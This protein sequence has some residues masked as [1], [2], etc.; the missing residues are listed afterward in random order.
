MQKLSLMK[1][2]RGEPARRYRAIWVLGFLGIV[3]GAIGDFSALSLASQSVVAPLGSWTLAANMVVAPLIVGEKPAQRE[4]LATLVIIAGCALSVL[5]ANHKTT[6]Y[7][8]QY[9]LHLYVT[10]KGSLYFGV[11]AGVIVVSLL[12]IRY[13]ERLEVLRG[14]DE[15]TAHKWYTAAPVIGY[16][17]ISGVAGAQTVVCAKSVVEMLTDLLV[18]QRSHREMLFAEPGTYAVLAL[19]VLAIVLQIYWL[20]VGMA[21][22]SVVRVL[23]VFQA[24]WVAG[25]A[26][27][28]GVFYNEFASFS[29]LQGTM[30]TVGLLV[31]MAGVSLLSRSRAPSGTPSRPATPK[32]PAELAQAMPVTTKGRRRAATQR[33]TSSLAL[34]PA[35][36][37]AGASPSTPLL[38]EDEARLQRKQADIEQALASIDAH[39]IDLDVPGDALGCVMQ[40]G[41][42]LVRD[43]QTP[44][45]ARLSIVWILH[46]TASEPG[47][48]QP[49]S[50]ARQNLP[51]DLGRLQPGDVLTHIAGVDIHS[52]W[53]SYADV[54]QRLLTA[55]RPVQLTFRRVVGMEAQLVPV[56]AE[57]TGT[58]SLTLPRI[59]QFD[60][61]PPSIEP[62]FPAEVRAAVENEFGSDL[63]ARALREMPARMRKARVGL[64]LQL[65][66]DTAATMRALQR[67]LAALR[68]ERRDRAGTDTADSD[69][70][71]PAAQPDI[72]A[73]INTSMDSNAEAQLADVSV[74]GLPT[75]WVSQRGQGSM[76]AD[77]RIA[78]ASEQL[79]YS[80]MDPM[81]A[82][83][84]WGGSMGGMSIWGSQGNDG[85]DGLPPSATGNMAA[86]AFSSI[87]PY[88]GRQWRILDRMFDAVD[89]VREWPS[90]LRGSQA[91][92]GAA[93][94]ARTHRLRS[95]SDVS[96][97]HALNV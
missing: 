49:A 21:R 53:L 36:P 92:A 54:L 30:F 5:F 46:S 89:T 45:Q 67:E 62:T 12:V 11:V 33:E 59:V 69:A 26:I 86:A 90:R 80:A 63:P 18:H 25:G 96:T 97:H 3:V 24:T 34:V 35:R 83:M 77:Q 78:H 85:V 37:P 87:M 64:A 41:Y 44:L 42:G 52:P 2:S 76:T 84:A 39:S 38:R 27:G 50:P 56:P 70:G 66:V 91:D 61:V 43:V 74:A 94:T 32:T 10:P 40:L 71:Q 1:K 75:L 6:I 93:G 17:F 82:L 20:N 31:T 51:P 95:S 88:R 9:L 22:Y 14:E 7:S 65:H 68:R 58:E 79:R 15:R 72:G 13:A 55:P 23:P 16:P 29:A 47:A 28:G 73:L 8:T 60:S 81:A 19:M 48:T 4:V 57:R